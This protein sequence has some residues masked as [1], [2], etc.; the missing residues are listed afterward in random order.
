MI[1]RGALVARKGKLAGDIYTIYNNL[2]IQG[3]KFFQKVA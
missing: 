2:K 1:W 3:K